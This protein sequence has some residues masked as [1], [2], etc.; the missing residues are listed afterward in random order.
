M[1]KDNGWCP[2][3]MGAKLMYFTLFLASL[4]C[5]NILKW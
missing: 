5:L 3:L 4:T 1:T 2:L